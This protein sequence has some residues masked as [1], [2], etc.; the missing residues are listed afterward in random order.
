MND[1]Q[2]RTL[3]QHLGLSWEGYRRVRKGVKRSISKHMLQLGCS[4]MTTYLRHL[5]KHPEERHQCELLMTVPVSRFFRDRRLWECLEQIILP[6]LIECA[7]ETISVWSAGCA[8]GEEVYSLKILWHKVVGSRPSTPRLFINAT[9]MN[10]AYL[11]RAKTGRF[12][13]SSLKEVNQEIRTAYFKERIPGKVYEVRPLLREDILWQERNLLKDPPGMDFHMIFLRNNLLTYYND[14]M[15]AS[16][17]TKIMTCLNPECFLVIGS[18]ERLPNVIH[19]FRPL[20]SLEYVFR[21]R[22]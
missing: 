6:D 4:R 15:K 5:D 21:G 11:A 3:L 12:S 7:H 14:E 1:H 13:S 22:N 9:D 17:L 19:E 18:H 10:P 2:F 8:S 16:F 20:D